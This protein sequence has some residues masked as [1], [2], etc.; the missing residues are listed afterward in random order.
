M[1]DKTHYHLLLADMLLV[2]LQVV[3]MSNCPNYPKET[4]YEIKLIIHNLPTYF[5]KESEY[6][7]CQSETYPYLQNIIPIVQMD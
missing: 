4:F 5:Y 6:I 1:S 3:K 7:T 2:T